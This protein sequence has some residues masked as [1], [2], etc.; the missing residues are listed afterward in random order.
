MQVCTGLGRITIPFTGSHKALCRDACTWYGLCYRKAQ[1]THLFYSTCKEARY[2]SNGRHY[3]IPQVCSLQIQPREMVQ[4]DKALS[5]S[6]IHAVPSRNT[7]GCSG[8]IADCFSHRGGEKCLGISS[9]LVQWL[10][11]NTL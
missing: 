2:L 5:A 9:F 4:T 10:I 6:C 3:L 1:E 11:I 7:W 8:L